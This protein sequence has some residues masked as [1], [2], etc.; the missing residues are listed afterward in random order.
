MLRFFCI[1][2]LTFQEIQFLTCFYI[3]CIA[4]TLLPVKK[5]AVG[6][7]MLKKNAT[8]WLLGAD[9]LFHLPV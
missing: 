9:T 4:E 8:L 1:I 7:I 6:N 3:R 2:S 5:I